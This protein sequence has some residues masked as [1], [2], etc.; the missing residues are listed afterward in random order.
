ME[1]VVFDP[2]DTVVKGEIM[3]TIV[4]Y[5]QDEGYHASSMVLQDESN[6]KMKSASHK[7]T[8]FRRMRRAFSTETGRKW[9]NCS[10]RTHFAT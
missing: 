6:V 5:L 7:R 9:R 10:R 2:S 8:Q 4:Q 1:H 3:Q